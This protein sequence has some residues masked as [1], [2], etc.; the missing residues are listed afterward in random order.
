[1]H[2]ASTPSR[3]TPLRTL[4]GWRLVWLLVC[5]FWVRL[6]GHADLP[7]ATAERLP[8]W[9][10][11]NL[12]EKF[13]YRGR[14]EPFLEED[15][16]L[17]A[18]L[19]FNFVRLPMDY[20]GWIVAGDWEQL[21]EEALR[22]IDQAVAWGRRYGLHVC[23]N[24]HR[25]PGYTV[26]QPPEA[27]DLWT[28]A[29]AQRV[30]ALHWAAFA[31]RYRDVPSTHL[32]FN[33]LNEPAEVERGVFLAVMERLVAAIRAED[34]RRLILCDGPRWG[35]VP[36]PEL[37]TLGVASATRGYTPFEFTHYQAPWVQGARFP[38]PAWPRSRGAN[39]LLHGN[40]QPER[41]RPLVLT[42][43]FP[44]GTRLRARVGTVSARA[45]LI[46]EADGTPLL[47]RA[48]VCG[49][50][51]GEWK[52]ATYKAEWKIW[53]NRFDLDLPVTAPDGAQAFTLRV[54]E[55]DW[56][57]LSE[58]GLEAGSGEQVLAL[59]SRYGQAPGP[60][61]WRDGQLLGPIVEDRDWL[62]RE[63]V[64]PWV[65]LSRQGVGVM[66]GEWGAFHRTPHELT[67][68]WAEDCLHLW[69][70]AGFGWALWNFRG[71]FGI[72]DSGRPDVAYEAFHGHQL[73]RRF[74]NLLQRY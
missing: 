50:G 22:Q 40:G 49:P 71:P 67:L 2:S 23:L 72:L 33:L 19:G 26:A 18:S 5:L 11:F 58:I 57:H 16:R 41:Q 59:E 70:E 51:E 53:Q 37:R 52:Q 14:L 29:E 17:I 47:E 44:P 15:F 68:R 54:A 34:P 10:G 60:V 6:A 36:V 48:W 74:L 27:R 69:R 55:G 21:R 32:S 66:V 13:Q 3:R 7:E 43:P 20:R 63:H 61:Q 46:I 56:L 25:A 31:K 42:G 64:R 65:E 8:R 35:Q 1:M 12:L 28:D 24:F 45:R 38:P 4:P 9:R 73:D 39:G 62:W 30:C